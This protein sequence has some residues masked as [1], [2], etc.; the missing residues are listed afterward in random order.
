MANLSVVYTSSDGVCEVRSAYFDV[1][2]G[3]DG[4]SIIA[5]Y[6]TYRENFSVLFKTLDFKYSIE[7]PKRY[8]NIKHN[9][10]RVLICKDEKTMLSMLY[11]WLVGNRIGVTMGVDIH[12]SVN[13]VKERMA[14][15][16]IEFIDIPAFKYLSKVYESKKSTIISF[17]GMHV[18]D[19][20]VLYAN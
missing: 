7:Y 5:A 10:T 4:K 1:A 13:A 2:Y 11:K 12:K 14:Y 15:H 18:I 16:G 3:Q 20:G 9:K 17:A 19:G 6:V 8:C